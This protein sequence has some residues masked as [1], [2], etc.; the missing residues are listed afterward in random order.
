MD[1]AGIHSSRRGA[2][3]FDDDSETTQPPT[4]RPD[5]S[6]AMSAAGHVELDALLTRRHSRRR[7][8][9]NLAAMGLTALLA[10][11]LVL[12][13]ALGTRA[14]TVGTPIPIAQRPIGV[15][16]VSNISFGTLTLNGRRLG[17]PPPQAVTLRAGTN[18]IA[19]VAPPFATRQCSIAWPSL[20]VLGGHCTVSVGIFYVPD[21][22]PTL[23]VEYGI[24]LDYDGGDLPPDA[25]ASA[26]ATLDAAIGAARLQTNV[27]AGQRI[28]T[29]WTP[30]A[31]TTIA[32]M[33]V[34]Q[35][36][37]AQLT[38]AP[39]AGGAPDCPAGLC[40]GPE[41]IP[42]YF[43][44]EPL[45]GPAW[46]L[47]VGVTYTWHFVR[48]SSA[49]MAS[50]TYPTDARATIALVPD[51]TGDG[52]WHVWQSSLRASAATPQAALA[53]TVC[54]W[55]SVFRVALPGVPSPPNV[56]MRVGPGIEGCVFDLLD[57]GDD[58]TGTLVWRFGVLLAGDAAAHARFPTLPL[59]SADELNAAGGDSSDGGNGSGSGG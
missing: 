2:M 29:A 4:L 21:T 15:A 47:S 37:R 42:G 17:G 52:G 45:G 46:M 53:G 35:S 50:V 40:A 24:M 38:F 11:A 14:A 27:P 36:V 58:H 34:S 51:S 33:G 18:V 55:A 49:T 39:A 56:G 3:S 41:F 48:S 22:N 28:A 8:A 31:A 54:D 23:D 19:L 57:A 25:A 32:S 59:A 16:L 1:L 43:D 7:R 9:A 30:R 26:L 5:E 12:H 13:V 44:R 6:G 10:A 20:A